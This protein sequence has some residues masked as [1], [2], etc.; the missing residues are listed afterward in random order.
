MKTLIKFRKRIL[1]FLV[2]CAVLYGL[3]IAR[4]TDSII[5]DKSTT[6]STETEA[7][8]LVKKLKIGWNLGNSLDVIS[9]SRG[10]YL[11]TETLWK[12]PKVT[13][14]LIHSVKA[15]GFTSIRIPVSYYNHIDSNN[16]IDARW[17]ARV[18][19]VVDYALEEK[20]YVIINIH[21]DTG[22]SEKYRWI[23]SDE[24]TYEEDKKNFVNLW[25]QIAKYF[26]N[27]DNKLL[28][29]STN[30][31][32]DRDKNWSWSYKHNFKVTA[33]LHNEFIKTVRATGGKNKKRFL[34]LPTYA[35][36]SDEEE[37]RQILN[38]NYDDTQKNHLIVSVHCYKKDKN[39]ITAVMERL[40]KYGRKYNVPFI[41]DEFAV[42]DVESETKRVELT[43]H[44]IE[45]AKENNVALFWWDSGNE[46]ALFDRNT[47][48]ILYKE[49][50]NTLVESYK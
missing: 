2:L 18:K 40:G 15:S 36:S 49:I 42:K 32:M 37:I 20:M 39:A 22:L 29:E 21:H 34:V 5:A 47:T 45:K 30:E 41:M 33:K 46:Y 7:T 44:Y 12:N 50:V 26:K 31:I 48:E 25:K 43:K 35:A 1:C 4:K 23:Y 6:T 10:Y 14:E 24:S 9:K 19:E 28:F 27:A 3:I 16:K 13:K 17:L 11:D 38:F 8:K